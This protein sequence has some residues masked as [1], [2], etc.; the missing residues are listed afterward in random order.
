MFSLM[1][2]TVSRAIRPMWGWVVV[3][4]LAF[5]GVLSSAEAPTPPLRVT[6]VRFWSLGDT[7]RRRH[8]NQW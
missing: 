8:R 2:P 4:L 3:S 5:V 1:P 6:S 7:T